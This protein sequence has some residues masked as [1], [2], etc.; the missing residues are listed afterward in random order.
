M[1]DLKW[2]RYAALGG[3]AFVVLN[4]V[5]TAFT[6]APPDPGKADKVAD[7]FSDHTGAIELSQFF[8]ILSVI[9]LLWWFGSLW[10][11]MAIAENGR[12]R[13][14]IVA[15][16]GLVFGGAMF[17]AANAMLSATALR[18][19]DAAGASTIF[20]TLS[21]VLLSTAGGGVLTFLT[22]V[23][24]LAL[25][26]KMLPAWMAYLG[27]LSA[28]FFLVSTIGTAS[29]APAFMFFGFLGFITWCIWVLGVS[30][31][32]WKHPASSVDSTVV[33]AVVV[34]VD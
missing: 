13:L 28:A 29:D 3:V 9:A 22:A 7:W 32:L 19:D 16:L 11:R 15:A 31:E 5:G 17:M 4:V 26:T 8:G 30:F 34:A 10:R 25:R 1:D 21:T 20:Y 6:G 2:E 24:V 23:S 18:L 33:A 14:S 12:H 27:L